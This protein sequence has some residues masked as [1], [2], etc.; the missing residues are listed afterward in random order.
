MSKWIICL[1]WCIPL[2]LYDGNNYGTALML[3]FGAG[4]GAAITA[5][6]LG[7]EL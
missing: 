5:E 4:I 1:L 6:I 7:V 2:A 3:F